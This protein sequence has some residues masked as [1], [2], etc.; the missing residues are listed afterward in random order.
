MSTDVGWLF[1]RN[2][3]DK[4]TTTTKKTKTK[5][6]KIQKASFLPFLSWS[7]SKLLRAKQLLWCPVLRIRILIKNLRHVE[8]THGRPILDSLTF[9]CQHAVPMRRVKNPTVSMRNLFEIPRVRI[10]SVLFENRSC[11]PLP[12]RAV[13]VDVPLSH[14]VIAAV[15]T[16]NLLVDFVIF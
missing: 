14:V 2:K 5:T 4:T 10:W 16:R 6:T 12:S 8:P 1:V 3:N 15:K 7:K 9:S 13:Q 11:H